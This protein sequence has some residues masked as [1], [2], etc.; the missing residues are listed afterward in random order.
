MMKLPRTIKE[1]KIS[2]HAKLN[3]DIISIN[4]SLRDIAFMHAA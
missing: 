1:F 2:T 3:G 4:I